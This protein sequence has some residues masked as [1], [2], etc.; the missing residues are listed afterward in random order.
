MKTYAMKPAEAEKS[1]TLIDADGLVVG[2]LASVIATRLR[3]KH[4]ADF[5]PHVDSGD[6]IVVVNAEKVV[7]TGNKRAD[8]KYY[9][10][11]GYPGG[12]K[13]R[14]ADQL[15]VGPFPDRVIHKAV[16]RMLPKTKLG[17]KQIGKLKIYAG[18]SHPHEAQS[19]QVLD[20]GEMNQK[21]KR[22][23]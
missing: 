11:T 1:W 13:N 9:W 2:R 12:I 16:E 15:L 22:S 21:N 7:F 10:H 20:I 17:K 3:G 18:G 8:K 14:T 19:P 5:T 6:N 4:R 23:V